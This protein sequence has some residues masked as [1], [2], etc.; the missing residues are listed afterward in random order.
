MEN[1]RKIR[2]KRN[3]TQVKLSIDL[4]LAQETISGYEMGR[5]YPSADN[6]IKLADYLNTSTDYLL[7]RT[8][9][10]KP[11]NFSSSDLT[12]DEFDI[13][14]KFRQLSKD[15]QLRVSGFIEALKDN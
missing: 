9:T 1:L 6:L 4:E 13:I 8:N 11:I 3:I 5:S 10:D 2:E 12:D 14:H 7:G 15:N